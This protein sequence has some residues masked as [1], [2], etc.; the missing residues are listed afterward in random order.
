MVPSF[1]PSV[2]PSS[3]APGEVSDV[4]RDLDET[5]P[6]PLADAMPGAATD[7]DVSAAHAA[8]KV[9]AGA[10]VDLDAALAHARADSAE[11]VAAA[12]QGDLRFLAA[13]G[14]LRFR[15]VLDLEQVR[16]RNLAASKM[17]RVAG[18]VLCGPARDRLRRQAREIHELAGTLFQRQD[19]AAHARICRR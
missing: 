3:G 1:M 11:P 13:D 8:A 10:A 12:A 5:A 7:P 4:P 15:T 14:D 2:A 16:D 17:E 18:D 9:V 19:D 6:H